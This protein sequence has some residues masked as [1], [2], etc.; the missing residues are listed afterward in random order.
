[1]A[2]ISAAAIPFDRLVQAFNDGY[3]G[4]QL[5]VQVDE[6]ELRHHIQQYDIDLNLSCVATQADRV[7]GVGLLAVRDQRGWVGGLGVHPDYR[8]QGVGRELMH[9]LIEQSRALGLS[10]IQ[11]EVLEKNDAAHRLYWNI[12]FADGRKLH[13]LSYEPSPQLASA[14]AVI[15]SCSVQ[16]ALQLH[17][18]YHKLTTP[19]QR[20]YESLKKADTSA[21]AWIIPG[22]PRPLAY[23][24]GLA[25]SDTLHLLDLA[26]APGQ[27]AALGTLIAQLH[28]QHPEAKGR[29][30]NIA[31][32]ESGYE[33]LSNAGWQIALSQY[34]MELPLT[35]APH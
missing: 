2:V 6:L 31:D 5:P 17:Q 20:G 9:A 27:E 32:N 13:V 10:A 19:W 33:I 23:A 34:E 3:T 1:M 8:R 29:I 11:L 7:T 26:C 35:V 12:G 18:A 28:R 15:A 22:S 21:Q 14:T 30:V 24:I 25:F 16:Q 4:Y